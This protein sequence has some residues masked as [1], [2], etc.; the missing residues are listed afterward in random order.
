[1][2]KIIFGLLCFPAIALGSPFLVCDPYPSTVTQPT[3]FVVTI[4]GVTAPIVTPAVAVTGGVAM[5]LDLGPMNLSGNKTL[6][7]KARNAWGESAASTPFSF[8]AG[9]PGAPSGLGLVAQ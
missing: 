6:T 7:A 9:H 1:L 4:S 2:K 3:E 8:A 5:R